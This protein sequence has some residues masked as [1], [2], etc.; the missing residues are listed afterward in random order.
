MLFTGR[1]TEIT[2]TFKAT[3]NM[4]YHSF[5]EKRADKHK[6]NFSFRISYRTS[7]NN[8]PIKIRTR[9]TV[10][11]PPLGTTTQHKIHIISFSQ[12]NSDKPKPTKRWTRTDFR[13]I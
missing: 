7:R 5:E 1:P 10:S 12:V 13:A 4:T 6:F 3:A 9:Q 2:F 11:F 8:V